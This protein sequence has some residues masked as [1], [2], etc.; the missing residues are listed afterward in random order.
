MNITK[1]V[2]LPSKESF[3]ECEVPGK[4]KHEASTP[5]RANGGGDLLCPATVLQPLRQR[6]RRLHRSKRTSAACVLQVCYGQRA[7]H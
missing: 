5:P 2:N 4:H 3:I 1:S 6:Q 7:L